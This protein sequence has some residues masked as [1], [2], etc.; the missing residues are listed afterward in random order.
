MKK[1]FVIGNPIDHSQSPKLHNYWLK[2]NNINALYDKIKL[3]RNHGMK[4]RDN[5]HVFGVNSRLD[6]LNAEVLNFRLKKLKSV[7]LKRKKNISIY[8]KLINQKHIK[9]PYD[10]K[11][12]FS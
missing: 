7:I 12:Q 9:I 5:V 6:V 11:D 4:S 1:Y 3:Y 2:E 10:T 8:Q